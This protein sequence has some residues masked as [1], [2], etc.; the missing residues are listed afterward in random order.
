MCEYYNRPEFIPKNSDLGFMMY[1]DSN[2]NIRAW[3]DTF[4]LP[5]GS[6]IPMSLAVRSDVA[7]DLQFSSRKPFL[8]LSDFFD[9]RQWVG[10]SF[11]VVWI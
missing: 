6:R 4:S 2:P 7:G 11:Y 3:F 8:S 1:G 9:R 5:E 10:H